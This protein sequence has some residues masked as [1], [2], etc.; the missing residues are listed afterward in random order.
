M[1]G[2]PVPGRQGDCT[3]EGLDGFLEKNVLGPLGMADTSFSLAPDRLDDLAE[4]YSP[5]PRPAGLP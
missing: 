4:V 5:I 3:G 1:R 2:G